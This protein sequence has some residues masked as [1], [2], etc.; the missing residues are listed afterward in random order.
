MPLLDDYDDALAALYNKILRFVER[1]LKS[2]MEVAETFSA[3][4]RQSTL[5]AGVI[6][7]GHAVPNGTP[8]QSEGFEI[9]SNVV[10]AEI[11]RAIM[12]ELGSVVFAA[13]RPDDF[14]QASVTHTLVGYFVTSI[15]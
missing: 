2:L 10:F 13:G 14:R 5:P 11:G 7:N 6:I 1:D 3:K 12:E 9:I 15:C 4:H 8:E